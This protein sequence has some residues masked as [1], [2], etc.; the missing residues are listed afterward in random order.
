MGRPGAAVGLRPPLL[1]AALPPPRLSIGWEEVRQVRVLHLLQM[2][3]RP[4]PSARQLVSSQGGGEAA[5][6]RP[7]SWTAFECF[8]CGE[9]DGPGDGLEECRGTVTPLSH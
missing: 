2:I 3:I 8:E 1:S 4:L 5:L 6:R 9:S 7:S